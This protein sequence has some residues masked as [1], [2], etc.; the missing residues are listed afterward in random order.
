MLSSSG[1]KHDCWPILLYESE[2]KLDVRRESVGHS[3]PLSS[4]HG[5]TVQQ[6]MNRKFEFSQTYYDIL[7]LATIFFPF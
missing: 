7:E 5:S 2:E 4:V 3:P 6:P 1:E